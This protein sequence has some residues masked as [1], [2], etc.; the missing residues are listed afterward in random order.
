MRLLAARHR[1]VSA[2]ELPAAAAGRRRGERFA[3]AV[4][5]DD[6][7]RAHVDTALPSL[8]A[9]STPATFFLTGASLRE[10][11]SFWWE[12]LQRAIDGGLVSSGGD[13]MAVAARMQDLAPAERDAASADLLWRLGGELPGSGLRGDDVRTLADAGFEI[14]FHTRE[15]HPLTELDDVALQHALRDGRAQL[16][17]AARTALRSI[18]YPHGA[19][20]ARVADAARAA[21]YAIGFTTTPSAVV[22]G[23]DRLLLGRIYPAPR[24]S[25]DL[26]MQLTRVLWRA[27]RRHG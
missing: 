25:A 19:A 10:P 7:L 12:R 9:T 4:T 18:A 5:F 11:S 26:A 15:H 8:R 14:G 22:A 6:D 27:R 3:V 24:S 1:V 20:D 17:A 2:P 16:E 21:G 23:A 13:A